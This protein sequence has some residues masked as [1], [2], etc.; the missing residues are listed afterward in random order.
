MEGM[1]L[2]DTFEEE[3]MEA[4]ALPRYN[5]RARA[6][7]HSSNQAQ[8]L[9]PRIFRP[10]AFTNNQTIAVTSTQA[11]NHIPMESAVI[12]QDTGA[13]LEYRQLIK[14]ETSFPVW[15]KTAANECGRLA[16]GV[17]GKIEGSNTIFFIPH[18]AVSKGKIVTY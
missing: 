17:I 2:F 14:S 1:N 18:S 4:P 8:F 5:T 7:Q 6:R 16:Q 12:N 10:V 3:H 11:P 15:N 9:A 13:S